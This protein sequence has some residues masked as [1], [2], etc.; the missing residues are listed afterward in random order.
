M[1]YLVMYKS[2]HGTAKEYARWL[3]D[4]LPEAQLENLDLCNPENFQYYS[5][6]IMTSST[7]MGNISARAYLVKNWDKLEGK[8]ITL[9]V[10]GMLP[11]NDPA[12]QEAFNKIPEHIRK[13]ITYYKVTGKLKW[14]EL[15]FLE[16]IIV[17]IVGKTKDLAPNLH[18]KKEPDELSSILADLQPDL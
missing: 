17:K 14:D 4:R 13:K 7:Y 8:K 6:I 11:M 15:G 1:S 9:L 3:A 2:R 5:N 18:S 10:V 16:K 12:S